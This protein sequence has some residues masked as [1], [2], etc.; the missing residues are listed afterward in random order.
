MTWQLFI[1]GFLLGLISSFHCIGMC[2]PI[3]LLLPVKQNG[4]GEKMVALFLY[5]IGRVFTY[6]ILGTILGVVGRRIYLAGFEQ[7]FSVIL[8]ALLLILL[9]AFAI[10]KSLLHK[11][12]GG[13]VFNPVQRIIARQL[14]SPHFSAIFLIGAANG[15]LP[16][17]M[18]YFALAGALATGT[19]VKAVI[20]M[21]AFGLGTAPLM[22]LMGYFGTVIN[23]RLRN[24]IKNL[25]PFFM[26]IM[27]MLLILRGLNL[28]IPY[29]SPFFARISGDTVSC[30]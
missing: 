13:F 16:C 18:V 25:T 22:M 8:G 6:A 5:N 27:A 24:R 4:P 14:R 26:G 20:F 3:A 17:G 28:N 11:K 15:L 9:V 30:H 23:M 21:T 29:I 2:G 12:P 7:S 10:N 19:V 1:P